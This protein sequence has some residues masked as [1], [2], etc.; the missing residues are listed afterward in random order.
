VPA[1]DEEAF[2]EPVIRRRRHQQECENG[3]IGNDQREEEITSAAAALPE[4]MIVWC[5]VKEMSDEDQI[6]DECPHVVE[7]RAMD[8]FG[9]A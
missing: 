9:R 3:E 5:H 8:A 4:E 2:L 7:P 1:V 6:G